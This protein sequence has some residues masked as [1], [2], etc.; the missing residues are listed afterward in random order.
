M[1]PKEYEKYIKNHIDGHEG[2]RICMICPPYHRK[3]CGICWHKNNAGINSQDYCI[4]EF[5]ECHRE[6]K[7]MKK[8]SEESINEELITG[9]SMRFTE[10]MRGLR[11]NYEER[12]DLESS[13]TEMEN[14]ARRLNN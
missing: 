5:C 1:K 7:K 6:L 2:L 3:C 14:F 13:F 10:V 8:I 9:I 12:E 11:L 4:D